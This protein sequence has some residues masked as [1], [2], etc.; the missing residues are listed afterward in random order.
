MCVC[1]LPTSCVK[2][3]AV[4]FALGSKFV[5]HCISFETL[6]LYSATSGMNDASFAMCFD[7]FSLNKYEYAWVFMSIY[8]CI[9]VCMSIYEY[10]WVCMSVYEHVWVCMSM[11][12]YVWACMSMYEYAWVCMSIYTFSY[13]AGMPCFGS[14]CISD[15][16][17]SFKIN[18][19]VNEWCAARSSW[20]VC[21]YSFEF[22]YVRVYVHVYVYVYVY[23]CMYVWM[24]NQVPNKLGCQDALQ[25][26]Q[27]FT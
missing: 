22:M 9:W 17:A 21:M 3:D 15:L 11:Y 16:T 6:L 19:H 26:C 27:S 1:V 18:S 10:E 24:Y 7:A 5:K 14:S 4:G 8:E 25:H 23:V 2:F 20:P 13:R 12:E